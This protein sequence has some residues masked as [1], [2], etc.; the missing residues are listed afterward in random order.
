[1]IWLAYNGWMGNGPV[2]VIV[3]AETEELA[4][5]AAS[6]ALRAMPS[7]RDE[8]EWEAIAEIS[9]LKLPFVGEID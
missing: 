8:P 4:R 5:E 7:H 6:A 2:A 9:P 3:E 1:M